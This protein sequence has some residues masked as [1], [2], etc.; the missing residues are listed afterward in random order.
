MQKTKE[1]IT[2]R[3]GQNPLVKPNIIILTE[4]DGRKAIIFPQYRPVE[5]ISHAEVAKAG[6]VLELEGI[7]GTDKKTGKPQ[8]YV[9]KAF[10]A[11]IEE[12][13]FYTEE[14]QQIL[15]EAA[16]DPEYQAWKASEN[17]IITESPAKLNIKIDKYKMP[18]KEQILQSMEDNFYPMP[19]M[20]NDPYAINPEV[21]FIESD[22]IKTF[23]HKNRV[24][25]S[26]GFF[27]WEKNNPA[28]RQKL[29]MSSEV[30][31]IYKKATT[32]IINL[33]PIY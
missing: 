11:K 28:I 14:Q 6:E 23:I 1:V 30:V 10:N 17:G 22:K 9:D 15:D 32:D 25:Y 26:D 20:P 31:E 29:I 3:L 7:W 18:T 4:A 12:V 19:L 8:F 2:F 21:D 33:F 27:F 24:F 13:S 16:M 5:D